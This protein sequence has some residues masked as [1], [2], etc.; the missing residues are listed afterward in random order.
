MVINMD[1][2]ISMAM[3][4]DRRWRSEPVSEAI[5]TWLARDET[6]IGFQQVVAPV[7]LKAG[8]LPTAR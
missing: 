8:L 5:P 3:L 4:K 1:E 7:I 2:A 6:E